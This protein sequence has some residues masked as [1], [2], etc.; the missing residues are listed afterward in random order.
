MLLLKLDIL[1]YNST[2][3][4]TFSTV[5]LLAFG[6]LGPDKRDF[7]IGGLFYCSGLS[8]I[9]LRQWVLAPLAC[10]IFSVLDIYLTENVT[11]S[12]VFLLANGVLIAVQIL[13]ELFD[14]A[15]FLMQSVG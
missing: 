8:P 10:V 3:N 13:K 7:R 2:K 1:Y 6:V 5:F 14:K 15:L 9:D 4:S 12:H 11:F